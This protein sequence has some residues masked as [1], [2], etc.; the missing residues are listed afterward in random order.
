MLSKEIKCVDCKRKLTI[1]KFKTI[2]IDKC[3]ECLSD[4]ELMQHIITERKEKVVDFIASAKL[5]A[6]NRWIGI[7]CKRE[8]LRNKVRITEF[9]NSGNHFTTFN[10]EIN[11]KKAAYNF[12]KETK[13]T[14][15]ICSCGR[16]FKGILGYAIHLTLF[17]G[18]N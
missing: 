13:G 6:N 17:N 11:A 16:K 15:Y 5:E 14:A 3:N 12:K 1:D 18:H 8:K 7:L 2:I 4:K 9:Y 10:T